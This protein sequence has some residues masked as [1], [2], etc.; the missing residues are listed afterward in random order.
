MNSLVLHPEA[1]ADLEEIGDYIAS[2]NPRAA[3]KLI[4]EFYDRFHSLAGSPRQGH[5][6]PNLT[7]R[8]LLFVVVR[9]YLVAYAPDEKPLL[10]IAVIHGRRNP[11][12][13][14]EILRRR[15]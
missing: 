9:Q 5:R 11:E 6:R 1:L 13:I 10:I 15:N 8:P 2:D 7:S 4:D 14:A 3:A 12:M